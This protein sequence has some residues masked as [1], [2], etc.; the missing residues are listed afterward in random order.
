MVRTISSLCSLAHSANQLSR[1]VSVKTFCTNHRI[2][3]SDKS[4]E[5]C[6]V[7]TIDTLLERNKRA[8]AEI[9]LKD[10]NF[11][12]ELAKGQQPKFLYFGCSDARIAADTLL[13]LKPGEVF[14]HRNLGNC[15][16]GN[17]LNSLSVLEYAVSVLDVRHII[18][19]GHYDCGAVR[20]AMSRKEHGLM[21]NWFR[22]IRDVYRLH[23]DE[24]DAIKDPEQKHRR[25]VELNV[26]EQCL[27]LYKTSVVQAKRLKTYNDDTISFSYP[28]I[29]GVTFDPANGL[30]KRLPLDLEFKKAVRDFRHVYDLYDEPD[31][32]KKK[33][34]IGSNLSDYLNTSETG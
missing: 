17:D 22:G 12:N 24:L 7:T 21:E 15:V 6:P 19:G 13:G 14:V 5:E 3:N 10:P 29:H 9:K 26:M 11:F 28:R 34:I 16:P 8:V 27:N 1:T 23:V 2:L 18:V 4:I 31:K 33:T 32:Q 20:A 25:F 30:L